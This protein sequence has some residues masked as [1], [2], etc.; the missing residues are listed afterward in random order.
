[1]S[2]N[3]LETFKEENDNL[4][5]ISFYSFSHSSH[6]DSP[7]KPK[8]KETSIEEL[9]QGIKNTFPSYPLNEEKEEEFSKSYSNDSKI[10]DS[11]N[12]NEIAPNSNQSEKMRNEKKI[13]KECSNLNDNGFYDFYMYNKDNEENSNFN[14]AD[15]IEKNLPDY[16]NNKENFYDKHQK[17]INNN[18][19]KIINN[20]NNKNSINCIDNNVIDNNR[21]KNSNIEDDNPVNIY[22][23]SNKDEKETLAKTTKLIK[24]TMNDLFKSYSVNWNTFNDTRLCQKKRKRRRTRAELS[25]ER[26]ILEG[27]IKLPS[28]KGR[29]DSKDK[30]NHKHNKLSDD[31]LIK[32]INTFLFESIRILLNSS[33]KDIIGKIVKKEKFLKLAP[34]LFSTNLKK[35]SVKKL[36]DQNL[37]TIFSNKISEKYIKKD[38]DHN[39]K[40]IQEILND[41]KQTLLHKILK[42]TFRQVIDLFIGK[43]IEKEK[44]N[45]NTIN[46]EYN[47]K[48]F[49]KIDCFLK[50]LYK[51]EKKNNENEDFIK[52]YLER[53]YFL[54][55]GYEKWFDIKIKR[56]APEGKKSK[57]LDKNEKTGRNKKNSSTKRKGESVNKLTKSKNY[58]YK[59]NDKTNSSSINSY[60]GRTKHKKNDLHIIIDS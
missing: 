44:M 38:S 53:T 31:N 58:V 12:E 39:L 25:L 22:N 41:S 24:D 46:D 50:K 4:S 2:N 15:D 30:E 7:F 35:D 9:N 37:V 51:Q 20:K 36:L 27:K 1:M 54:C 57:S 47:L 23:N 55:L 29:K 14:C 33:F 13:N 48:E 59:D 49:P 40:L 17:T 18:D 52:E 3:N 32:K 10:N 45:N 8:N 42:L 21:S 43:E 60:H 11:D 16:I 28:K 56:N 19:K 34:S 6:S 26:K 5:N